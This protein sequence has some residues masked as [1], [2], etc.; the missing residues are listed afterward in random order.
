MVH[1]F[2]SVP[3]AAAVEIDRHWNMTVDLPFTVYNYTNGVYEKQL[4]YIAPIM[5]HR[6]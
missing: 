1:M 5:K 4:Q 3:V 2:L 6:L